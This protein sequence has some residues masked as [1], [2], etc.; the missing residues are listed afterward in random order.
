LA[1]FLAEEFP[2]VVVEIKKSYHSG[3]KEII[4]NNKYDL[5]LLDISMPTYD[6][7]PGETGGDPMPLAGKLILKEMYLRD[8]VAKVIVVTMYESFVDGTRLK[9]LD[10]QL[11]EEFSSNYRGYVYFSPGNTIWRSVLKNKI[12]E[13]L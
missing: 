1:S 3:L 9:A 13:I 7:H 4:L 5:I 11:S 6:I 10:I 2:N 8:I 12:L